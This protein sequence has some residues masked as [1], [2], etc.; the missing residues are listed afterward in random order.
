RF[1]AA[2]YAPGS[3]RTGDEARQRLQG[4]TGSHV[5]LA[6]G[7]LARDFLDAGAERVPR[8]GDQTDFRVTLKARVRLPSRF[9]RL[10]RL[11]QGQ[12]CLT[13]IMENE[14]LRAMPFVKLGWQVRAIPILFQ[15]LESP[16]V[17]RS[18][19]LGRDQDG[20]LDIDPGA[21]KRIGILAGNGRLERGY[22]GIDIPKSSVRESAIEMRRCLGGVGS[23]REIV[24]EE[25]ERGLGMAR[26]ELPCLNSQVKRFVFCP[27][28]LGEERRLNIGVPRFVLA[29]VKSPHGPAPVPAA[30][31]VTQFPI[32]VPRPR[33][34]WLPVRCRP[35]LLR[36]GKRVDPSLAVNNR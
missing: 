19:S 30:T 29:P 28:Q 3:S 2:N 6:A 31:P 23:K 33:S 32:A 15:E 8:V 35:V 21:E 20:Q 14:R 22:R 1:R 25:P 17:E 7:R 4:G 12:R 11:V 34:S 9:Q 5:A 36:V 16:V 24:I 27:R 18:F 26:H 10:P 13:P